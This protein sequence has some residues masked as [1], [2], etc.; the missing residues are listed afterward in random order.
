[1]VSALLNDALS[2]ATAVIDGF[3]QNENISPIDN[4][5]PTRVSEHFRAIF[6]DN[7]ALKQV[8]TSRFRTGRDADHSFQIPPLAISHPPQLYRSKPHPLVR[9]RAMFVNQLFRTV[10]TRRK[11]NVS[12]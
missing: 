5:F 11:L 6:K 3:M 4:D 9:F 7:D 10:D 12:L 8:C 1:M 2:N